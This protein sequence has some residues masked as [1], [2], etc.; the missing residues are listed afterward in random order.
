VSF[1]FSSPMTARETVSMT[2]TSQLVVLDVA[3][4]V[5]GALRVSNLASD[6]KVR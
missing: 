1:S 4:Q 3:G 2:T 6:G 5:E